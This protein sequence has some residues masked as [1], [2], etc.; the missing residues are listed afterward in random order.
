MTDWQ[1]AVVREV[2]SPT[3]PSPR[4]SESGVPFCSEHDCALY[5]GKRCYALGFRPDSICEPTV[6]AMAARLSRS[7]P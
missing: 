4:W 6:I 3:D 2:G 1:K 7:A 5:D